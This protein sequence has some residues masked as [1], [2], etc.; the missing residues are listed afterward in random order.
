MEDS[1]CFFYSLSYVGDG[2]EVL[3]FAIEFHEKLR[4]ISACDGIKAGQKYFG[5]EIF[6]NKK[7]FVMLLAAD[8]Q[9]L[10]AVSGDSYEN[11]ETGV[12]VRNGVLYRS[13]FSDAEICVLFYD[14][15]MET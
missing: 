4:S 8:N 13:S 12:V 6:M 5:Q 1:P 11:N 10:L 7:K 15:T 9:A 14:G 2:Q 3:R